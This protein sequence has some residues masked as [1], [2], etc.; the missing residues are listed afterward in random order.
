MPPAVHSTITDPAPKPIAHD[1]SVCV[2]RHEIEAEPFPALGA[3]ASIRPLR[4]FDDGSVRSGLVTLG[5]DWV[6]PDT[7]C[8]PCV[9]QF[10]VLEGE[11]DFAGDVLGQGAFAAIPAGVPIAFHAVG[12]AEILLIRD[13]DAA[14][15]SGVDSPGAEV[16]LIKDVLSTE[17]IVPVINGKK[18]EGF[19]RRVLWEDPATGADTRMLRI[20]A[21]FEGAGGSNFHPVHEEIF[22]LEG[23]IAPDDT[24]PMQA[25]SF[26]WNPRLA[27]HGFREHSK[28]GCLLL[29]WHDG[30][31]A[32]HSWDGEPVS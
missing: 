7:G 25:G 3:G 21:G 1:I 29:E 11:I 22:C 12:P 30:P 4:R 31:W 19:E 14:V 16:V 24:R 26:L 18:L 27:I 10:Y 2:H 8:V 5:A 32:F 9:W 17:P 6:P 20:P 23:D 13:S 28:G 15:G